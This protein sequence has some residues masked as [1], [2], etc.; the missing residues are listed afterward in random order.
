MSERRGQIS[1]QDCDIATRETDMTIS[2][3]ADITH[4]IAA[5]LLLCATAYSFTQGTRSG[6]HGQAALNNQDLVVANM[7]ADLRDFH[8]C[9]EQ[10]AMLAEQTADF[11]VLGLM[12][13]VAAIGISTDPGSPRNPMERMALDET[14]RQVPVMAARTP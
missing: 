4:S 9:S 13:T 14:I 5:G 7:T 3:Q 12:T 8:M 2:N 10:A 11:G 1:W 6:D